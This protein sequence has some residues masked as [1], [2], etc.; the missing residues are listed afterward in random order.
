M[1]FD[2]FQVAFKTFIYTVG[3]NFYSYVFYEPQTAIMNLY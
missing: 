2:L 1:N 3:L